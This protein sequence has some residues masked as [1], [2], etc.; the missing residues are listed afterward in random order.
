MIA[1]VAQRLHQTI[2]PMV[3]YQDMTAR[4][5]IQQRTTKVNGDTVWRDSVLVRAARAGHIAVLDGIHRIHSST[6]SV[7][8]RLV[9][10]REMQLY[11]GR[12]LVNH[13]IYDELLKSG[14]TAEQLEDKGLLRIHPSFRIVALA[15]PP[16]VDKGNN[17]LT[18][19][20]LS[21]FMFHDVRNLSK[22]E[23][24]QIIKELVRNK[25]WKELI[26]RR[27]LNLC[28]FSTFSTAIISDRPSQSYWTWRS[29]C[30]RQRIQ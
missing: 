6:I 28:D 3:L 22:A 14:M 25:N 12:R 15:D 29:S 24:C 17:W 16:V 27:Q 5:L 10:D 26:G 21:L 4:D 8:H 2:D 13:E 9:H 30:V 11:D 7:L 19:E 20:M 1:E 18:P 23:E